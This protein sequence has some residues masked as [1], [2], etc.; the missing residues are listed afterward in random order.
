LEPPVIAATNDGWMVPPSGSSEFDF[1]DR[2]VMVPREKK[3]TEGGWVVMNFDDDDDRG[4]YSNA[5]TNAISDLEYTGEIKKEN[6][7]IRVGIKKVA[8]G[9]SPVAY[10]FKFGGDNIRVWKKQNHTDAVNSEG[11]ELTLSP[12]LSYVFAYIE[13]IK[14]HDDDNGTLITGQVKIGNGQW[15]DT[16]SV[17]VRVAHP[18]VA[19]YADNAEW[20]AD[21]SIL[22]QYLVSK[23]GN[24]QSRQRYVFTTRGNTLAEGYTFLVPG[25]NSDGENVCYSVTGVSGAL[26]NKV[27]KLALKTDKIDIIATGHANYGIGLAFGAN[28]TAY[29]DFFNMAGK[30]NTA[31]GH[32]GLENHPS[33]SVQYT[34]N[35]NHGLWNQSAIQGINDSRRSL[36]ELRINRHLEGIPIQNVER[37]PH[38]DQVQTPPGQSFPEHDFDCGGVATLKWHFLEDQMI[39]GGVSDQDASAHPIYNTIVNCGT[40]DVPAQ[41]KYRSLV[42]N[43]CNSLRNFAEAF[44]H[45]NVFLS[46]ESVGS[47]LYSREYVKAIIEGENWDG[48]LDYLNVLDSPESPKNQ[49]HGLYEKLPY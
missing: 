34:Q 33:F 38:K 8:V 37:F 40:H 35:L 30:G 4:D 3:A 48:V 19:L 31:M 11:T 39:T 41:L 7:M 46:W 9:N 26:S 27:F 10:R 20:S 44:K 16:E 24:D 1:L 17:K 18:I 21:Q 14:P 28:F 45:G 47:N 49:G 32:L 12:G 22:S 36:P 29:N 5:K 2:A 43:S 25:K 15:I 13:G 42:I 6:D 23:V